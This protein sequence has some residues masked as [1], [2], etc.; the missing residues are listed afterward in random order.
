MIATLATGP[1]GAEELWKLNHY[2]E[3]LDEWNEAHGV[4][5]N[6]FAPA[7]SEPLFEMHNLT[8]D[9]EERHNRVD[10]VPDARSRLQTILDRERDVKRRLPVHRNPVG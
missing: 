3:R 6:P 4:P 9:P 8:A 5:T 1:R 7:P 10:D 2:Y